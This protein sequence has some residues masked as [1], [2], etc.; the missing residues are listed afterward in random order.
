MAPGL[1]GIIKAEY[2]AA[3][4]VSKAMGLELALARNSLN[5]LL[6]VSSWLTYSMC[7]P[8]Q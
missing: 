4:M 6:L 8:W 7:L 3:S 2:L 5:H 1:S